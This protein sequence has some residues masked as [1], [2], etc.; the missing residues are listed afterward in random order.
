MDEKALKAEACL[1]MLEYMLQR[2]YM[3]VYGTQRLGSDDIKRAHKN[4]LATI[5]GETFPQT[6]PA[7][8]MLIAGE[9]EDAC[10][11]F[12]GTLDEMLIE[13]STLEK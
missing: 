11:H 7:F 2:L 3:I 6:D 12:L 4:V 9:P 1:I 5:G 10:G 8:S 13:T